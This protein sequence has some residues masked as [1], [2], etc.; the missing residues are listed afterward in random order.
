MPQLENESLE[1]SHDLTETSR[2]MDLDT[3]DQYQKDV[4]KTVLLY[5]GNNNLERQEDV[6]EELN[7]SR[8]T[9]SNRLRSDEAKQ[10]MKMFSHKDKDELDRWFEELAAKH[11]NKAMQ[12]LKLAMKKASKREDVSPQ[13]LKS[14]STALLKADEQLAKNLQEFGAI[15]K[16]KERKEVTESSGEVVFNE[17]IV[18]SREEL[19]GLE[20]EAEV[21]E[22]VEQD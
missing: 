21:E 16:P 8:E 14:C 4:R 17:E 10:F 20:N 2:L 5:Y 18:E 3:L 19:E 15:K 6:A 22:S 11:Y 1:I 12:G 7:V 13:V 9:V